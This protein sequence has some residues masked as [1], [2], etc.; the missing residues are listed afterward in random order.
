MQISPPYWKSNMAMAIYILLAIF[1][2]IGIYKI[3]TIRANYTYRLSESKK[4]IQRNMEI[5]EAKLRFFTN[6]SHELQSPLAL[7][8][9]PAENLSRSANLSVEE[10]K[11]VDLIQRNTNRLTRLIEQLMDFRKTQKEVTQLTAMKGDIISFLK[12]ITQPYMAYA[13]KNN[14]TYRFLCN[15]AKI[16]M[17]F[18]PDKIEKIMSNLLMNAFKFTP[19]GGTVEV[20]IGSSEYNLIGNIQKSPR[21]QDIEQIINISIR[22]TGKGM[23]KEELKNIFH[24]FYMGNNSAGYKGTGIGLELTKTLVELHGGAINVDSKEG[25]GSTFTIS[26]FKDSK[27]LKKSSISNEEIIADKYVSDLNL[28]EILSDNVEENRPIQNEEVEKDKLLI[29]I[30]EDNGDLRN[31][32]GENLSEY[33]NVLLA[34][35]G[36]EGLDTAIQ[37]VPDLIIS[38]VMMPELNGIELTQQLKSSLVTSHI[39]VI[40]LTRKT[41]IEDKITGLQTGADDYVG[42]PFNMQYLMLRINNIFNSISKVKA[43]ILKELDSGKVESQG[44]S[45]FDKKL[46]NKCM[47]AIIENLSDPEFSVNELGTVIG[48]SRSQ[49][50]RKITALTGHTPADF[51]Y[52]NRLAEAKKLLLNV[53]YSVMD[54]AHMTG[55]KSSNSFSTV[56]KKNFG[57]SPKDYIDLHQKK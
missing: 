23:T 57:L 35:D 6:I 27:H 51:I 32:L 15:E 56:F 50:Y 44:I 12:E 46:L 33:Y 18:D 22:D 25:F 13:Q 39:P 40:L 5:N 34:K 16:D 2:F 28:S 47:E 41:Q 1:L 10:K 14:I 31:F 21:K 7:I 30:V 19:Q 3:A 38:D 20:I 24:R 36:K 11:H 9:A 48:M 29:L 55:F 53:D 8:N 17:W 42:K 49:L 26:L 54:V 37:K 43:Q 4:A 52:S 45:T